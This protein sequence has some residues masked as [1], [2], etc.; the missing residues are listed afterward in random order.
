MCRKEHEELEQEIEATK[1]LLGKL[2]AEKEAHET[3]SES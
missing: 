3:S 1:V 2:Q